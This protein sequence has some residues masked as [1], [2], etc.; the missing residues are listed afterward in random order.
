MLIV[1][2]RPR[3]DRRRLGQ[4]ILE[5]QQSVSDYIEQH[6]ASD[7]PLP[8]IDD[9]YE[10][11]PVTVEPFIYIG[12]ESHPRQGGHLTYGVLRDALQG[13]WLYLY[14]EQRFQTAGFSVE[15]EE[16]GQVGIG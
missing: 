2:R 12:I 10:S 16:W 8:P 6:H 1:T 14:R 9:P 15:T 7:T 13:L 5:M 3:I 4:T 11:P